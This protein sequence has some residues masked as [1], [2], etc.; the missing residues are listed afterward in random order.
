MKNNNTII[1][2]CNDI[3]LSYMKEKNELLHVLDNINFELKENEIIAIVGKS[4]AGKSTFLR[5]MSG[6]IPATLGSVYYKSDL[7][8]TPLTRMSMVFQNFA[9]LPW[10]SVLDN[11]IFG[12][13]AQ[14]VKRKESEPKA[15]E[16][17][18]K[19]G[20]HGFENSFISE[21]S[22][23]MKQRVGFARALIVEPEVLLMDEPFSS[24][25]ITTAKS[26]REEII[27]LWSTRVINTKSMVIVTHNI[28]EAAL[29]ADR[30]IIFSSNPGRIINE[31]TINKEHPRDKNNKQMQET[32]ESITNELYIQ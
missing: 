27:K 28:E 23:G 16:I 15:R 29:M 24:L 8:Q 25:D 18:N 10:L 7:V 11:V 5:V 12:L 17:I 14:G 1:V 30:V 32:I 31:F 21:L 3:S 4:G 2:K 9:L 26:L 6:L 22:G 19:I 20:L 13:E